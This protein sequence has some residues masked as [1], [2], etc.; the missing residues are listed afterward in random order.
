MKQLNKKIKFNYEILETIESGIVLLGPEVKSI[1]DGKLSF[2]DS[3][4]Y[5]K[6]NEVW[7]LNLHIS[8]YSLDT[9]LKPEP[10]RKRKLLLKK[11][12]I[13][14]LSEKLKKGSGLTLIPASIYQKKKYIKCELALCKGKKLHDKRET[15]RERN[16]K[17]EAKKFL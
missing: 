9:V 7:L 10:T 1:R 3:F 8:P 5:I 2:G 17:R 4:A 12:E 13:R 11:S 6:N 14:K 15:L 16:F